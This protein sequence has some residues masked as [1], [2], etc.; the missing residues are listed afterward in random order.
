MKS[1]PMDTPIVC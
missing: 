1:Q